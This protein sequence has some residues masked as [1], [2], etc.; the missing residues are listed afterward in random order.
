[1]VGVASLDTNELVDDRP[2]LRP[3]RLQ[4]RLLASSSHQVLDSFVQARM[5][6]SGA[7]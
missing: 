2:L 4:R 6:G 3:A 1:M 5:G 7:E